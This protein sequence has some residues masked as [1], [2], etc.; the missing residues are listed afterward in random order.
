LQYR[1]STDN[2][3]QS[4]DTFIGS[5][6]STFTSAILSESENI[7]YTI[8]NQ[9]GTRYLLLKADAGNA[10]TESNENN[11]VVAIAITISAAAMPILSNENPRLENGILAEA[12][13]AYPNPASTQLTIDAGAFEWTEL[14]ILNLNGQVLKEYNSLEHSSLIHIPVNSLEPGT[15]LIR[16]TNASECAFVRAIIE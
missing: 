9:I 3:W 11:N 15:Y 7:T 1:L 16:L 10:V 8:P 2:V 12:I 6:L 13:K 5:D 4:T 14:A